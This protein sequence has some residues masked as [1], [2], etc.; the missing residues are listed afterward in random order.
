MGPGAGNGLSVAVGV[1]VT[2]S[3]VC[4]GWAG[5]VVSGGA[6]GGWLAVVVGVVGGVVTT[7]RGVG[8]GEVVLGAAVVRGAV[9]RSTVGV[10]R[11]VVAA[12]VS[13]SG[14]SALIEGTGADANVD[15]GVGGGVLVRVVA[16]ACRSGT[17]TPTESPM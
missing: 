8:L 11:G 17:V 2:V 3:G 12:G 5:S 16:A 7:G 10:A 9:R 6:T 1:G 13:V 4:V 14:T 15:T